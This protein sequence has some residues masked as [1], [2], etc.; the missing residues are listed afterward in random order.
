[1]SRPLQPHTPFVGA[2]KGAERIASHLELGPRPLICRGYLRPPV[3]LC[4]GHDVAFRTRQR[5][6]SADK[7]RAK[8]SIDSLTNLQIKS[9]YGHGL[10]VALEHGAVLPLP[11]YPCLRTGEPRHCHAHDLRA[12]Y[13]KMAYKLYQC[14]DTFNRTACRCLLHEGLNESLSYANVRLRG[15]D[16]KIGSFGPLLV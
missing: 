6:V 7:R 3:R 16:E 11:T 13:S 4:Q 15:F 8:T 2:Y 5:A 14:D 10:N 1:M 9:R 12:I